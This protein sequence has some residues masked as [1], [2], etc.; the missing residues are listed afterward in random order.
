MA[1]PLNQDIRCT[2]KAIQFVKQGP[3]S[4]GNRRR[5]TVDYY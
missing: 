4:S 2:L 1:D 3:A 5:A